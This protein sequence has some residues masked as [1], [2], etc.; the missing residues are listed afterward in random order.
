M[1]DVAA[2][3]ASPRGSVAASIAS[4]LELDVG[5]VP[6]PDEDHPEPWK[7]WRQW[8]LGRGLGLVP[9][10]GPHDFEW[11]GPW[12]ALLRAAGGGE[13]VAAVAYGAPPGLAWAPLRGPETFGDVETGYLVA[14][15]DTALWSPPRLAAPRLEGTVEAILVAAEAEAPMTRV[16][17]AAAR[18]DRGLEG[19]RY[20]EHRGTF[21]NWHGRGHDLTLVDAA[22]LEELG[23]TAEEARRNVVVRGV[24]LDALIG[25]TFTVGGVECLGQRRCEPCAHLERV[26][27][28]PGM[29]RALVRRGGLRA[30]VI[31]DGEVAAGDA[32]VAR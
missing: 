13:P 20:F 30:D 1:R 17:R 5:D 32:V 3:V 21:S 2:P 9:I 7:V 15:N 31:G 26:N 27:D 28:R 29:L 16:E 6:L 8:L 19:D 23:Y 11:P 4:I 12:L 22:A 10:A 14:P 24:D 25:R 18:R